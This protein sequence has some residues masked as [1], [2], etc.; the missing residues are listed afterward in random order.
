MKIIKLTESDL[1]KI[2][3][4]VISEQSTVGKKLPQLVQ[5]RPQYSA[6]SDYFGQKY[7]N[8]SNPS[9]YLGRGA[10]Y[11]RHNFPD[12]YKRPLKMWEECVPF[13]VRPF[14]LWVQ[15]KQKEIMSKLGID[16]ETLKI[17][18]KAAVGIFG[19]ETSFASSKRFALKNVLDAIDF[20]FDIFV[21]SHGPAQMTKDAYKQTN[22]EKLFGMSSDDLYEIKGSGSAVLTFLATSYKKALENGYTTQKS[23]NLSGTGN[24]ALD[25]AIGSY[26]V[27]QAKITKYCKTNIQNVAKP[28][29]TPSTPEFQVSTQELKNYIPNYSSD[30]SDTGK[31]TTHGYIQEVAKYMNSY[32]CIDSI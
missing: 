21:G 24:S 29:G 28:C 19:R 6:S 4:R 17:L 22:V 32:N 11:E 9:D 8:N 20:D 10:G 15:S 18:T 14:A 13:K 5:N 1:K 25:M 12:R 7:Q 30:R 27:G 3:K 16:K 23:S 2:V 26:N 31:L